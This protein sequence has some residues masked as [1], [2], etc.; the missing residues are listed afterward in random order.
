VH[1]IGG[2]GGAPLVGT[3]EQV[4]DAMARMSRLGLDGIVVSWPRYIE[5][6][7]VFQRDTLPLLKQAGLR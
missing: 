4:V 6:M 5:D 2:W 3:S 1:F 7:R